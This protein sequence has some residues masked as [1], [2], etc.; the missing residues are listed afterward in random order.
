MVADVQIYETGLR[1]I[2]SYTSWTSSRLKDAGIPVRFCTNN[3]TKTKAG[4]AKI[5]LDLGFD[6]SESQLFPPPPAVS[7]VLKARSL[8]PYLIVMPG[9]CIALCRDPSTHHLDG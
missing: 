5:L 1:L 4:L 6:V 2:Y 7:Q 3:S 8:R 9:R